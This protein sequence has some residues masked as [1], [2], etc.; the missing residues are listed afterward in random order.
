MTGVGVGV[1]VGVV[2]TATRITLLNNVFL[3]MWYGQLV[4]DNLE[5]NFWT[6]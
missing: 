5:R 4:A 2:C 1:G 3:D 6:F